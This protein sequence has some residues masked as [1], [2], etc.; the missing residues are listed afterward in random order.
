MKNRNL[1]L[2]LILM[3]LN[4]ITLL[5][6][7]GIVPGC[8]E[9]TKADLGNLFTSIVDPQTVTVEQGNSVAVD[10]SVSQATS[11]ID[12]RLID[13]TI[14]PFI[15]PELQNILFT[16]SAINNSTSSI[17]TFN[18]PLSVT[19]GTYDM[20][21]KFQREDDS[22]KFETE[23]LRIIVSGPLLFSLSVSPEGWII[24]DGRQ[25]STTVTVIRDPGF[26]GAIDLLV[27][28][29][30]VPYLP[31]RITGTFS[32]NPVPSDSTEST[33]TLYNIGAAPGN[34]EIRVDGT[35]DKGARA[36]YDIWLEVPDT[37]NSGP[38]WQLMPSTTSEHLTDLDFPTSTVG[39]AVGDNGT[40]LKSMDAGKTWFSLPSPTS[41][42][43]QRVQFLDAII[44]FVAGVPPQASSEP[45][46]FKTTSGGD[47]W[48]DLTANMPGIN[49]FSMQFLDVDIGYIGGVHAGINTGL[50]LF[51]ND[52]GQNWTEIDG[53]WQTATFG[54][55]VL[56]FSSDSTGFVSF[57][58]PPG[59]ASIQYT[60]DGGGS[61][62]PASGAPQLALI[63]VHSG[64]A[65]WGNDEVLS[66]FNDGQSW[67]IY[68]ATGGVLHQHQSVYRQGS[69]TWLAGHDH[70]IFRSDD[71]T[72]WTEE[73]Y[74]RFSGRLKDIHMFSNTEGV[75]VGGNGVILRRVP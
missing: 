50:L 60:D 47:N 15:V 29:S 51:T 37:S 36:T 65:V 9:I 58:T 48:I 18:V 38:L 3:G 11:N 8:S 68:G 39:Y 5:L 7:M 20:L 23:D 24:P 30:H 21:V 33:L 61:W 52:G 1:K 49:I 17:L 57:N 43:L 16:P 34:Y 56:Q 74:V 14:A 66:G 4:L 42:S 2:R 75:A 59:E 46:L 32:L 67:S 45:T 63:N 53:P 62:N 41:G 25:D 13:N 35:D 55:R 40:I 54:I 6:I 72:N 31:Q 27:R 64:M 69:T 73:H 19:P 10:I 26:T 44:G 12:L 22:T 71:G 70:G 28:Q